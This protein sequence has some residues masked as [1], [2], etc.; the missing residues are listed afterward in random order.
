M[1]VVAVVMVTEVVVV[2]VVDATKLVITVVAPVILIAH[3]GSPS[4]VTTTTTLTEGVMILITRRTTNFQERPIVYFVVHSMELKIV[5][6]PSQMAH[7][8]SGEVF[9][10]TGGPTS[11]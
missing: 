5:P 1:D 10:G 9:V 2:A 11:G 8:S 3:V 7:L 4:K 6:S